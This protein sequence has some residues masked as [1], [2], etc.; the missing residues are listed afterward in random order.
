MRYLGD[1]TQVIP[2]QSTNPD[3]YHA[4]DSTV[5][6]FAEFWTKAFGGTIESLSTGLTRGIAQGLGI[7]EG[8]IWIGG[9]LL[10]IY[11]MK[12]K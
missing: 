4:G 1:S 10:V 5:S 9:A 12:K 6:N 7:P 11:L 8:M 2:V 3:T